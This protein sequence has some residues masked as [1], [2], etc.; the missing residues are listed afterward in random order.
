MSR[1]API[2]YHQR[3]A[4]TAISL[5]ALPDFQVIAYGVAAGEI[6]AQPVNRAIARLRLPADEFTVSPLITTLGRAQP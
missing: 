2:N 5:G 1:P 6:L 3:V 4:L